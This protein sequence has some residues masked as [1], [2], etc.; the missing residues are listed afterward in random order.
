MELEE[1]FQ[2]IDKLEQQVEVAQKIGE[3]LHTQMEVRE[4]PYEELEGVGGGHAD[5]TVEMADV[6]FDGDL[7]G[8]LSKK[9]PS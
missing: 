3:Q 4:N 9:K 7:G 6:P 2:Q 1:A 5:H 8:D